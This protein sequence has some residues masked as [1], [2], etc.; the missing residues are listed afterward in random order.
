MAMEA[1]QWL[2]QY[3]AEHPDR[4]APPLLQRKAP[5]DLVSELLVK[6][7]TVRRRQN[8]ERYVEDTSLC[9][10]QNFLTILR[11][12]PHFQQVR[13][14]TMRGCPELAT[15]GT[16]RQ[17]TDADD[18]EAR[19]YIEARY[20]L[21]SIPKYS[22]A[23][24]Q[25]GQ[26]RRYHP[27]QERLNAVCTVEGTDC[28]RF[29]IRWMGADDT[30]YNREVTRLFFAG[31]VRRAFEP[32]CKFDAVPVLIGAQGGGKS[33]IC[34]WL[35]LEDDFYSSAKTI[36]GQKGFEAISGKW[37]VEIEELLAVLANERAGQKVEENAKAF[38][39]TQSDYYRR[40]YAH[41][42]EDNPRSC[43]FIGTT[44]RDTFLTDKTGNRR[45][46][47]IRCQ[48][49]AATLYQQEKKVKQDIRACWA[50]MTAAYKSGDSL[51]DPAPRM[52]LLNEIRNQQKSAEVEDYRVGLIQEYLDEGQFDRVCILQLWRNAIHRDSYTTPELRRK[53]SIEL[54][55]ILTNTLGWTRGGTEYFAGMGSQKAFFRPGY[56]R[57]PVEDDL[58]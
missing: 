51:A 56:E 29:F 13:F 22:D 24:L 32:G 10:A 8:G 41:R 28:T 19:T 57:L 1:D 49:D 43:V 18:A 15:E 31:G 14:N 11:E 12:D 37:V 5:E 35:A 42:P 48:G 3:E 44:N 30:P 20:G 39:S 54:G 2:T 27:V 7:Q 16:R 55:E 46:F 21:F 38:L 52:D 25:F 47:P 36:S 33:T 17:W 34:R 40:P 9:T 4:L 53:D 26:E 23:F 58:F 50:Q 45:W 6:K